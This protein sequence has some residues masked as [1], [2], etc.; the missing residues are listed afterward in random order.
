MKRVIVLIALVALLCLTS[1]ESY[2]A[3]AWGDEEFGL[4]V[5]GFNEEGTIEVGGS[6]L[7]MD[8]DDEPA[9][10]GAYVFR[11]DPNMIQIPNPIIGW[12]DRENL[13]ASTYFG[14]EV[15]RDCNLDETNFK[16]TIGAIAEE[17]LFIER[18]IIEGLPDR[19]IF[20]ATYSWKF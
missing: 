15:E 13:T 10:V 9:K 1:C 19:T 14:P 6:G 3:S 18:Q 17:F 5:G 2:R 11:H 12:L 7:W 16:F 8:A 20:G 4:R